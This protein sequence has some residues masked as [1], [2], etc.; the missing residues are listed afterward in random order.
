MPHNWINLSF[1]SSSKKGRRAVM[2]DL[3]VPRIRVP[4]HCIPSFFPSKTHSRTAKLPFG[5]HR[6]M[7]ARHHV[8]NLLE[9]LQPAPSISLQCPA[10]I[11][12]DHARAAEL[13]KLKWSLSHMCPATRGT[14]KKKPVKKKSAPVN[15]KENISGKVNKTDLDQRNG[16]NSCSACNISLASDMSTAELEAHMNAYDEAI[17]KYPY[18]PYR[19]TGSMVVGPQSGGFHGSGSPELRVP[20][21]RVPVWRIGLAEPDGGTV[22]NAVTSSAAPTHSTSS[23]AASPPTT[24]SNRGHYNKHYPQSFGALNLE[25]GDGSSTAAAI[26]ALEDDLELS[27]QD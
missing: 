3:Y 11:I 10:S 6:P 13:L 24:T 5:E 17:F 25:V 2:G 26:A 16:F 14:H 20:E 15:G 19:V 4:K 23:V 1:Y 21:W 8:S 9:P 27:S 7:S 18:K 12:L 22:V